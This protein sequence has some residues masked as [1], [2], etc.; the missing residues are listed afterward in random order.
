M[1]I[2]ETIKQ[3]SEMITA[4]LAF[5]G[6][7]TQDELIELDWLSTQPYGASFYL[8]KAEDEGWIKC[9]ERKGTKGELEYHVTAKGRKMV[10]E[11]D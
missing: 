1:N 7:K 2:T 9:R 8:E 4:S 6:W 10:N 5:L 11:R 3:G